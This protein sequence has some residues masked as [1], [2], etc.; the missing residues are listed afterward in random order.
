MPVY[1]SGANCAWVPNQSFLNNLAKGS[2][3]I[4]QYNVGILN[5]IFVNAS[6]RVLLKLDV[7]AGSLESS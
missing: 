1:L 3:I 4:I 2:N 7:P 5:H 6:N